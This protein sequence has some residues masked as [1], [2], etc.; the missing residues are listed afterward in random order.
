MGTMKNKGQ[1]STSN[2]NNPDKKK[3]GAGST[4][5]WEHQK[6]MIAVFLALIIIGTG[7]AVAFHYLD[8]SE[9][10]D[11]VEKNKYVQSIELG[12]EW[13]LNNQDESFLY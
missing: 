7:F 8:D 10:G 9:N 1:S 4:I 12:G 5:F 13:F 3:E 6:K 11:E 2:R